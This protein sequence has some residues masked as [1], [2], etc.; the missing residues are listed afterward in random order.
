MKKHF[1][2]YKF[3]KTKSIIPRFSYSFTWFAGFQWYVNWSRAKWHVISLR[4][5]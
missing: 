2:K 3:H 5:M 1:K 4:N